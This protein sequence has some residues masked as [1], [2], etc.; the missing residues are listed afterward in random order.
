MNEIT[1]PGKAFV[2]KYKLDACVSLFAIQRVWPLSSKRINFFH[3]SLKLRRSKS[4]YVY[5]YHRYS[6]LY[7]QMIE[8]V[9]TQAT[10][11]VY[12]YHRYSVLYNQMIEW[13]I[14]Q[15]TLYIV[16]LIHVPCLCTSYISS[17][18]GSLCYTDVCVPP[19]ISKSVVTLC[20]TKN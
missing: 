19:C 18:G 4:Q 15:A 12:H 14:T 7:N 9:I 1:Q 10:L 8:W 5:H 16:H 13:V 3:F 2:Y 6:V 20:L 17:T 11:Y